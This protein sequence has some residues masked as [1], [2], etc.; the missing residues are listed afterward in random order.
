[1]SEESFSELERIAK[2]IKNIPSLK[3]E[4]SGHTDN[5]G[6]VDKNQELSELRAKAV[7]DFLISKGCDKNSLTFKGYGSSQ[8]IE[9][10]E[11]EEGRGA[12]R[13]TE[14]KILQVDGEYNLITIYRFDYQLYPYVD[15]YNN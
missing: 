1:M 3:M 10:N 6:S 15:C 13:R 14:F 9:S 7:M 2:L 8:A 11:T 12:N 5:L 4:I